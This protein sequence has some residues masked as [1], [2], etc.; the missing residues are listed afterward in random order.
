MTEKFKALSD[1]YIVGSYGP[2]EKA[3]I[4]HWILG[5]AAAMFVNFFFSR[6]THAFQP[7]SYNTTLGRPVVVKDINGQYIGRWERLYIEGYVATMSRMLTNIFTTGKFKRWSD[8]NKTEQINLIKAI[9]IAV[10]FAG[11]MLMYGALVQDDKNK[12]KP[13]PNWRIIRNVKYAMYSLLVLPTMIEWFRNPFAMVDILSG[14]FIDPWGNFK[15]RYPMK[16]QIDT[17]GEIIDEDWKKDE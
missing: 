9:T 16:S 5:R 12:N 4:N 11:V 6:F 7:G 15:I 17:I 1:K 14:M 8:L 3:L 2:L 10:E 13:I